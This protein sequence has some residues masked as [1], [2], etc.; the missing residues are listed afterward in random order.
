MAL[1]REVIDL[2]GSNL[3]QEA[4]QV[5]GVGQIPVMQKEAR[6]A[7]MRI[8]IDVVDASGVKG[9]RPALDAVNHIA[10]V[11][12]KTR[13]QRAVLTGDT[14]DQRDF[15]PPGLPELRLAP[16]H[17]AV[18]DLGSERMELSPAARNDL[19]NQL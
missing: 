13:Q 6:S 5:G 18:R 15:S 8:D 12:K 16:E 1:R 7:L 9:R 17:A 11:E 14:G 19:T 10:L 4:N 2:G 3:L